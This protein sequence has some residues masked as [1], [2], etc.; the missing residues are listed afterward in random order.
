MTPGAPS[1]SRPP[2]GAG[3]P[4]VDGGERARGVEVVG[5]ARLAPRRTVASASGPPLRDS[6]ARQVAAGAPPARARRR[7]TPRRAVVVREQR[8]PDRHRLDPA[9]AQLGDE[10]EVA[11]GLA[12]LLAVVPH[13][14]LV[15]EGPGER[16]R[17]GQCLA[18]AGA[19]LVVREDQVGAA[20]LQVERH[21][22][23]LAG[24][25]SRTRC[26]SPAARRRGRRRATTARRPGAP[27]TAAGRGRRACP[28][29]RGRRPARRTPRA[30]RRG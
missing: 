18:V 4:G 27:A 1:R 21:A 29:G 9:F 6:P 25:W 28:R 3:H 14:R 13:H 10:D 17:S 16:L 2:Q 15:D 7:S 24:R 11:L 20:A 5:E 12:H 22:E 19:H 23:V 8:Q 26:A 30:S